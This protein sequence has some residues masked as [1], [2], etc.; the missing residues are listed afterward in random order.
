VLIADSSDDYRKL[1]ANRFQDELDMELVSSTTD[2]LD[3]LRLA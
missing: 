2:G 1:V 3:V